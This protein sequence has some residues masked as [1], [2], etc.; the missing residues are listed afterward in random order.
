V[1]K[2]MKGTPMLEIT[3]P[4]RRKATTMPEL[5]IDGTAL[6]GVSETTLWTLYCRATKRAE[7]SP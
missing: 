3:H 6:T 4:D 2:E 7:P 1:I 5:K